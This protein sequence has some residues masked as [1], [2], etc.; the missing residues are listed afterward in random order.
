MTYWETLEAWLFDHD[1]ERFTVYDIAGGMSISVIEASGLIQAYLSAQR[2][3]KPRTLYVLK[4][5]GRTK[6]A[7]W[8]VGQRTAD[9]RSIGK[10][11]FEDVE[12]KV[13]RAFAPDLERLAERNPRAARY[14][15][16]KIVAVIESA[17]PMLAASVDLMFPEDLDNGDGSIA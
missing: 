15:K 8:S 16:A 5:D 17:L 12:V 9:A 1:A 11:L 10:T 2:A 13:L 6:A 7:V 14:A 3:D 4:R